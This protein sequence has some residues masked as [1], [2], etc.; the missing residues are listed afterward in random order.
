MRLQ[1]LALVFNNVQEGGILNAIQKFTPRIVILT[2][3][4]ILETIN[5]LDVSSPGGSALANFM[6]SEKPSAVV[7]AM[8]KNHELIKI[9]KGKEWLIS[10][11]E[12][13]V[14]KVKA[15]MNDENATA[16]SSFFA[17]L[18]DVVVNR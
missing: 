9:F 2:G 16:I 3:R 14:E 13:E 10:F 5:L 1:N 4:Q 12:E 18:A 8:M 7:A 15:S 11:L 17:A 6:L